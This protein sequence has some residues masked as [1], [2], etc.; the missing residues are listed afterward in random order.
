MMR[1]EEVLSDFKE[2]LRGGKVLLG[3]HHLSGSDAIIELLAYAGF[4][5]VV[6]DMEHSGY[7]T[8]VAES[9]VRTAEAA[10][11]VSFIRVIKNDPTLIMQAMETGTQGVVVPHILTPQDCANALA[12]MRFPPYGI[13]GWTA[14][15]RAGRWGATDTGTY[16]EWSNSQPLLIPLIEDRDAVENLEDIL[17]VSGIEIVCLGPGDLSQ[18]Y[19]FPG[20]GLR[21][22]PVMA[23]LERTIRACVPGNIRVMTLP[24][25]DL[26]STWTREIIAKGARLIWYTSDL[27]NIGRHF[28]QIAAAVTPEESR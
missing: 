8:T 7:T 3:M 9:L 21:A 23:A 11:I 2:Q 10:G 25:P 20:M 1:R 18:S 14:G 24:I 15:S 17:A 16:Q 4:A 27:I 28:R 12:A 22:A 5:F 19:G 6:I 26:T 13:R